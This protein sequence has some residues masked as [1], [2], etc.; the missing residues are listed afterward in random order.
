VYT[1][2]QPGIAAVTYSSILTFSG[3]TLLPGPV[4]SNGQPSGI[5]PVGTTQA[6]LSA[7]TNEN[8][9]CR[10]ATT[11]GVAYSAMTN[12]FSTTGATAQ[13]TQLT[14][15]QN[16]SNYN[17]YVRC[18]DASGNVDTY[19]YTISFGVSSSS[20]TASDNF[21]G[22]A[23]V[24]SDNGLWQTPGSWSAMSENNG[25]Y[26][27]GVDAAMLTNPLLGPD[28]YAEITFSQDPGSSGS[29]VGVM[30]R[31]QGASNGSGYLAFAYAG[32]V[33][34]YRVD[35]FGYLSWNELA[36][37]SV[38]LGTA[39]RDLRL[40]SQGNTHQVLFNG[41]VLITYTDPNNVYTTGQPGIAA[42]EYSSILT[43]TGGSLP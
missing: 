28:E 37:A 30:T 29:W 3:G 23:A 19:D 15:L 13:S 35:D 11:S 4:L 33:W 38:N 14:G 6:T 40:Q 26:A 32:A 16:G 25:A 21:P 12:T 17:Y 22:T 31:I 18:Q 9:T 43:F 20:T 10:Y 36:S 7:T 8:A 24:L 39:P 2:G 1:A 27:A 34:L 41:V 42:V 5:L